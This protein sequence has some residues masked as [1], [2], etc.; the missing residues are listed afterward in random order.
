MYL[1][2]ATLWNFVTPPFETPDE[3]AH[4]RYVLFLASE[5]RLPDPRVDG[6]RS[7]NESF[8]PP[9]YYAICAA[10]LDATGTSLTPHLP[11]R[12]PGWDWDTVPRNYFVVSPVGAD[13]L[14]LLRELSVLFGLITVTCA[15]LAG[16]ILSANGLARAAA[17]VV[18]AA[19]PQ[20]T[21]VAAA[22]N[23]DSAAVATAS[24]GLVLLL[25]ILRSPVR[26]TRLLAAFGAAVGIGVL[27]EYHT[28]YLFAMATL[29]YPMMRNRTVRTFVI[30]GAIAGVA[31]LVVAGWWFALNLL[32]YG[33][34]SG[35]SMQ[36]LL[37][38]ELVTPRSLFDPYFLYFFPTIT[39]ESFFGTFGWLNVYL[40][41]QLYFAFLALCALALAG[42]AVAMLLR[43]TWDVPR[44]ALVL[45]PMILLVLVV[46]ANLTFNAPQGRYFFPALVAISSVLALGL[47]ELPR[48]LGRWLLIVTPAFLIGTN[49][50]SLW[51]VWGAFAR[52]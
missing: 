26:R 17:A 5:H 4:V 3:D 25:M 24:I 34:P 28:I 10:L 15:Y 19:L 6:A 22:V 11:T 2:L 8:H 18:T 42:V 14:H 46:Y 41:A 29:A 36:R 9:L 51:F 49:L 35:L 23:P 30:D 37:A 32:R 44:R 38:P 7:G 27:F 1:S 45:A 20:F 21:Y 48:P 12:V 39:F 16:T 43:R 50:Y 33:E 13:Y 52:G 47:A 31:F 40:P